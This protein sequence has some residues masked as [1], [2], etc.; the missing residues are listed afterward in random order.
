MP[1]FLINIFDGQLGGILLNFVRILIP[2]VIIGF[3]I[4]VHELGHFLAAKFV[5]IQVDKFA[6]GFGPP[7]LRFNYKGTEYS[8]RLIFLGGY[9]Q[10]F[11]DEDP[12]S[13]KQDR[14]L[15]SDPRSFISKTVPQ[16]IFVLVAGV[17]MNLSVG[18]ICFIFYL[19]GV[20]GV[21]G[22]QRI[23]DYN[24][25]GAERYPNMIFLNNDFRGE[26]A[27][28]GFILAIEDEIPEGREELLQILSDNEGEELDVTMFDGTEVVE[29]QLVLNGEG[30]ASSLDLDLFPPLD[31]QTRPILT[32]VNEEEG[33]FHKGTVIDVDQPQGAS[34][35]A[36]VEDNIDRLLNTYIVEI[37]EDEIYGDASLDQAL[38][39]NLGEQIT[40]EL[41]QSDGNILQV[42]VD[43]PEEEDVEEDEPIL[44]I[45]LTYSTMGYNQDV[46]LYRYSNPVTGGVTHSINTIGYQIYALGYLIS[47]A[48]QG[49]PEQLTENVGGV[50]AIGGQISE[51]VDIA[52][53]SDSAVLIELLNVT[54]TISLV[55]AF[56][57]MLPIPVLDGGQIMFVLLEKLRGKPL[58]PRLEN[59]IYTF[60]IGLL[61]ILMVVIT[62]RDIFRI[63]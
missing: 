51:V 8:F 35:P 21:V 32:R 55:L 40:M 31:E 50:V 10:M 5:G 52:A 46:F 54:A 20:D 6:I 47:D 19:V 27:D 15:E 39:D 63:I 42:L 11:G 43:L 28:T 7:L 26:E 34:D 56:M 23:G 1:D 45:G 17:G 41:L 57:N 60:F 53:T 3:L 33:A 49:Q 14:S 25:V 61:V 48:F 30:I 13:S 29:R 62:A 37:N 12:S 59:F 38:E 22:L 16:K 58:P 18:I 2:V 24:F 9:V 4:F 36:I 44:G